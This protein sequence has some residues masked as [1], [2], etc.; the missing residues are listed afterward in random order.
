MRNLSEDQYLKGYWIGLNNS[1]TLFESGEA[2]KT[3]N[4][5]HA[6]S[7]LILAAEEAIKSLRLLSGKY[8]SSYIEQRF[9]KYFS[10]HCFKHQEI[11][12][13]ERSGNILYILF[14]KMLEGGE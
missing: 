2:I 7:L 8:D 3:I 10:S 4:Y 12:D 11:S 5:G 13:L 9:N 14:E 1:I 6:I